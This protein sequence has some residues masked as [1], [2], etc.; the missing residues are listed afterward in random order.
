MPDELAEKVL[1]LI[2][3]VK[4]IPRESVSLTSTFEE[5]KLDSLDAIN[6][7]YELEGA[8]NISI[9]D[10]LAKSVTNV[11]QMVEELKKLI[12]VSSTPLPAPE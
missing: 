1:N 5:L 10:Q 7:F 6:L 12:E 4:R 8:F 2:A 11:Q 9:P 3:E